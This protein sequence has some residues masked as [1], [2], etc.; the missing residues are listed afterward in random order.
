MDKKLD[1]ALCSDFPLLYR[2]RHASMQGTAMCWGFDV[3]D[4]WEPLIRD[5][6]AQLEPLIQNIVNKIETESNG[7]PECVCGETRFEHI[8]STGKC[9]KVFQLPKNPKF[10]NSISRWGHFSISGDVYNSKKL[11]DRLYV[12]W[13]RMK[14]WMSRK[15]TRKLNSILSYLCDKDL[16]FRMQPC[17]CKAF[18]MSHPAASQVK[19]KFAT[20]RFYMTSA[21]DE[22]YD[23]I[24]K[25]EARSSKTCEVCG[26]PGV[27]RQGGWLQTLCD[28]HANG[29]ESDE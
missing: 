1:E 13:R 9:V 29:R 2:D 14:S 18:D 27:L 28:E 26:Q 17:W 10:I 16:L 5:L 4:G 3:G 23:L 20:L 21:T 12:I 8:N 11:K 22:M 7:N 19:E 6:S 25:A 15:I 24:S